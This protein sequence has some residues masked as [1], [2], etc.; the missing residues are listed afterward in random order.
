M[1]ARFSFP[2]NVYARLL[3]LQEGQVDYLH[4]GV[5]DHPDEPVLQAQQR[6]TELLW[7][8]LPAPGRLLEVGIG[9]GTTL[10][11]LLQQGWQPLGITPEPAQIDVAQERQGGLLPLRCTRLEDLG[12]D[13]GPFDTM[14]FQESAQYIAPMEIFAAADR[15][16]VKGSASIVVMDEFA[17]DRRAAD[18]GGLHH[19]AHFM[20]LAQRFGWRVAH[21]VDLSL[22]VQPTLQY[23]I[24]GTRRWRDRLLADL[25]VTARQL[26]ELD[27]ALLRVQRLYA[28][29]IQGYGVLRLQR[30]HC[31]DVRPVALGA[32]EAP[33]V[34]A[35]FAEVF[36]HE[37]SAA[38]W[39]W[40]YGQDRGRAFGLRQG[41]RLLAHYGG[42]T[43]AVWQGGE[44]LAACQVCDVIV[45]ADLRAHL[46]RRNPLHALTA[47][48]L[49]AEIGWGLPHRVGFGFP[50]DRAFGV[51]QRLGL[52]AAV[53]SMDCA[54]WPAQ[55]WRWPLPVQA[56]QAADLQAESPLTAAVDTL[57]QTMR[58]EA[59]PSLLGER[60]AAWLVHRYLNHPRLAYRVLLL[61]SRW[62]RRPLGVVVLRQHDNHLEWVDWVAPQ[63]SL[64]ALLALVRHEAA[65]CGKPDAQAWI[66][67]SHRHLLAGLTSDVSWRALG[68]EVPANAHTPGPSPDSLRGHWWLTAG[69]TDFR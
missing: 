1:T 12:A 17:L 50:T 30:D 5:F 55:A 22:A 37:L 47:S 38:E 64:P 31:P 20:A 49:E 46:A 23:L 52:Y 33:E 41:S 35:L 48:F 8:A 2:L 69:D 19:R 67:A 62:R 18:H 3:E 32:A 40:K 68:I 13:A 11:R 65:S 66:S 24:N 44:R 42:L 51:A 28:D 36:G 61:R 26:D 53:D 7:Q 60:D 56:L 63:A 57:W 16:L 4:F 27:A 43:R 58:A 9:L 10:T 21:Q 6:A 54:T 59:A 25:P 45:H 15:L 14:L 34:R 39:A 29:G